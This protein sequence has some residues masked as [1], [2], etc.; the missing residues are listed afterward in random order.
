MGFLDKMKSAANQIAENSKDIAAGAVGDIKNNVGHAGQAILNESKDS[1]SAFVSNMDS[2]EQPIYRTTSHIDGKNSAVRLFWDRIE[3]DI[4]RGFSGAKIATGALTG[5]ASLL[6]TGVKG[7]KDAF[8]ILYLRHVTGAS[9]KKDGMLYYRIE[10]TTSG[11]AGANLIPFRVHRNEAQEF[12]QKLLGAVQAYHDRSDG[13]TP[14]P[15]EGRQIAPQHATTPEIEP[16]SVAAPTI[17]ERL[18]HLKTLL[19]QGILTDEEYTAKRSALIEQ[20]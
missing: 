10:V 5:G 15:S 17:E 13:I 12:R 1:G 6:V 9:M 20:L 19:E 2:E 14:P 7:G 16:T 8:E 18:V 11:G 3:W 4:P